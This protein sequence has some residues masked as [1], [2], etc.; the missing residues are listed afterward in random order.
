MAS[1]VEKSVP[2]AATAA[3]GPSEPAD[4]LFYYDGNWYL[5]KPVPLPELPP[6]EFG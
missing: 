5:F 2:G 3:S 6:F 1:E 4:E